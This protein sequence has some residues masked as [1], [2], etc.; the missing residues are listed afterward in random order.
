MS[1]I[2]EVSEGRHY[3]VMSRQEALENIQCLAEQL[4]EKHNYGSTI[5]DIQKLIKTQLLHNYG[6]PKTHNTITDIQ[7][8]NHATNYGHSKT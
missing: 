6:H 2:V 4:L 3:L 8:L 5:T 1:E 7:K